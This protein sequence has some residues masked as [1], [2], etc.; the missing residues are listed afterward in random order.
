ML[1]VED[2]EPTCACCTHTFNGVPFTR[3]YVPPGD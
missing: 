1:R 3:K 2:M